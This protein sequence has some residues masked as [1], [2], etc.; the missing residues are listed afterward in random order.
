VVQ[1]HPGQPFIQQV[2][3]CC[4]KNLNPQSNPHT[5]GAAFL[6]NNPLLKYVTGGATVLVQILTQAICNSPIP[7]RLEGAQSLLLNAKDDIL[8]AREMTAALDIGTIDE[9]ELL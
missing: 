9:V 5:L 7:S 3:G 4:L 2:T 6:P 8:D 1:V